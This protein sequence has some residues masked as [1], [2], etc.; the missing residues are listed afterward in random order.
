M[1]IN[2]GKTGKKHNYDMK[3][4]RLFFEV[5]LETRESSGVFDKYLTP[6]TSGP[7]Y[8]KSESWCPVKLLYF[9]MN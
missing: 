9:M 1:D 4:V 5:F 6:V 8:D 7:I 2:K 3:A